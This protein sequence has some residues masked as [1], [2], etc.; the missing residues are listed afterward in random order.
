MLLIFVSGLAAVNARNSLAATPPMGWMSWEIF[1][2]ETD[3][4]VHPTTCISENLYQAQTSALASGGFIKAGYIGIHLDD[5]WEN[6]TRGQ[7]GKLLPDLK[8]FPSGMRNLGEYIHSMGATFGLYTAESQTTCGGN[9]GSAGYEELDATTFAE[10]GVDYMKVDGCGNS[11][12]YAYGYRAMGEALQDSGRDIVYSCSWPAY[13]NGGNESIQ[14]FATF[15]NDGCNLWRNW[16][17]I[18]C[19]FDSLSSIIDHWGDYGSSLQAAAGPGHWHD[20]DMLLIGNNC[21]S[22]AEERTQMAIWSVSASPLIMGN[23]LRNISEASRAILLNS[24]AIAV[25]QDPLGQM[26]I[27]LTPAS[28]TNQVWARIL[29][30]GSYAVALYNK[31]GI[32][33]PRPVPCTAKAGDWT[34]TSKGYYEAC[35]GAAGDLGAFYLLSVEQAQEACCANAKCVGISYNPVTGSGLYKADAFC[36]FVQSNVYDGYTLSSMIPKPKPVA[37]TLPFALL[38]WTFDQPIEVFDIWEQK[39]VGQFFNNFT[40]VVDFHDSAFLRVSKVKYIK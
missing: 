37:I 18:Q 26:G 4:I 6:E 2:C 34:R 20:M 29:H 31:A 7:D 35:G 8:R 5:C 10:W 27:R 11:S 23:D 24:A 19:N 16:D 32:V 1:R 30:D 17:D 38:H 28:E 22:L 36:G 13:I 9:P 15:I 14:P 21:I 12:Y 33:G 25:S 40:V 3:C 39:P